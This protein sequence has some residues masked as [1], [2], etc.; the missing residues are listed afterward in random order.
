ML[1]ILDIKVNEWYAIGDNGFFFD[2]DK[3]KN[4]LKGFKRKKDLIEALRKKFEDSYKK[5]H[6]SKIAK[7]IYS[8]SI[9]TP[10]SIANT[11][12]EYS[13]IKLRDTSE[14]NLLIGVYEEDRYTICV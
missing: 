1:D 7:G 2:K 13:I 4:T 12:C 10:L 6:I 9:C 8:I 11:Y 14:V 5:P 3:E